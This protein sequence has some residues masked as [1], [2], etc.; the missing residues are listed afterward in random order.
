[1]QNHTETVRRSGILTH[2]TSF[3][4]PYGIGD[5][6]E[7]A[8]AF[9]DF[10]EESGQHLWQCLPLGPT[11]YGDSPYQ[12]FSSFAGQPLIISPDKLFEMELLSAEDL[13]DIPQWDAHQID[14]GPAIEYK[15]DL[16]KK[17]YEHFKHTPVKLT[18][19]QYEAFCGAEKLW[20]DNYALFMALKDANDGHSWLEW[21]DAHK[22]ADKMEQLKLAKI[23]AD[24][25]NYYKFIQFIFFK[26][27]NELKEYA[28]EKEIQI[29][30]DIPIFVSVD[31]TDVWADKEL[32]QLDETGYPISVAGVPPDYFSATGQ[33]WGNPL[34]DWEAHAAQDYR[35]WIERIRKQL[36]L[37]DYLRIDHFRGFEAYWSVPYME[38]TAI[39]GSW[40]PGPGRD[41]FDA[42]E[43]ALGQELP[44]FA[45]DLGV[46][47]PAVEE[48]R[49]TFHFPGMKVLQFGFD[50][51]A[52]NPFLP[53]LFIENCICYTGTHDNDT[54]IGWYST[55][56]NA[57]RDKVRRYM[58]CDGGQ[59]HHDFIR[60]A[61]GS[62]AR[63]AIFPLQDL[64]GL[65]S[66]GRMNTPGT[67]AGN[68]SWRYTQADLG[69]A[70]ADDLLQLTILYGRRLNS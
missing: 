45:E 42:I 11:G 53:H 16:L 36:E 62:I 1:M 33:L 7:G 25:M 32:F 56:S 55:A 44:I 50:N 61:L 9:I 40:I 63:Y 30:G 54:T 57:S 46:I 66:E 58:N 4:S 48:L 69:K 38:E 37:T 49:D 68:W 6:G 70:L 19:E 5:L 51:V 43:K 41:L 15:T 21:P 26:Q 14:Y 29:I 3:P 31:S 20:L 59:V 24:P 18:L 65:S 27:W 64:L 23:L 13:A 12:S 39:N 17:S 35:W 34:Y 22:F 52:E 47:T 28:H 8:Y 2:P 67:P 60:T 10:L